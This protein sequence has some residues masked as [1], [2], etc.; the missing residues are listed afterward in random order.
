M[1]VVKLKYIRGKQQIKAHL[2]YITHRRGETREKIT[3]LLFGKDGLTDK[4]A[5]YEMI[6]SVKRGTTFF[7]IMISPD[8]RQEDTY[9]DLSRLPKV[10]S[11]IN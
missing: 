7:K 11:H 4:R 10:L 1:A 5:T 2:R 6:D 9:K 3:R 8:P